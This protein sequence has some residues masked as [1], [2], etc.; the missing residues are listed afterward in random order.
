MKSTDRGFSIEWL[1]GTVASLLV[2][3]INPE[4]P[5][6][7]MAILVLAGALLLSAV[8]KTRW[9][10][11]TSQIL[12]L[13]PNGEMSPDDAGVFWRKL[14]GYAV[15]ILCIVIFGVV[16]WP[17]KQIVSSG[18]AVLLS[19][20]VTSQIEFH[21]TTQHGILPN[22]SVSGSGVEKKPGQVIGN[23]ANRPPL[24]PSAPT[25]RVN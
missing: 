17:S 16:T 13:I 20:P 1:L 25:V 2:L 22:T 5:G 3:L 9:A 12:T 11:Q 4:Q 8:R 21:P 19:G 14:Q 6:W 7:R 10:N 24:P 18:D 23:Q 15:V